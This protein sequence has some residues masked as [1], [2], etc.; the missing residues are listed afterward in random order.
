MRRVADM[1]SGGRRAAGPPVAVRRAPDLPGRV[2]GT[3]GVLRLGPLAIP[4]AL[5][6]SGIVARKR[7][8]DGATPIGRHAVLALAVRGDRCPAPSPLPARRIGPRDG[9][10]DA[11]LDAAYN[12]PVCLPHR[13]SAEAMM[14]ADRL[15]DAVIVLDYNLTAR[16]RHRGSAVFWHV[17]APGLAPTE[18]C[19]AL[20]P[21]D[22]RRVL[23]HLR[24]GR[25]LAVI[26]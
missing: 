17:A 11:P 26:G 1:R 7:E 10:C 9:W 3:R 22:M 18:G 8:G 12:R 23:A 5:G 2:R 16:A 21:T 20:A 25:T 24:R 19:V 6:R 13:A 15:Y 14:R 4:C